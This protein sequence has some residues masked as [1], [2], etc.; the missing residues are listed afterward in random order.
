MFSFLSY[1]WQPPQATAFIFYGKPESYSEKTI[2]SFRQNGHHGSPHRNAAG[3]A[4]L[5]H[6]VFR[7][8]GDT[9][10]GTA[11]G[12][13]IGDGGIGVAGEVH[14]A[15]P[16][17]PDRLAGLLHADDLLLRSKFRDHGDSS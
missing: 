15:G 2:F 14:L 11:V 13:R 3:L 16:A 10:A 9:G 4:Q 5:G 8:H 6:G 7:F 17:L 1:F 12:N